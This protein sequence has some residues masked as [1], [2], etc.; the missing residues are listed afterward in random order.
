MSAPIHKAGQAAPFIT[1]VVKVFSDKKTGTFNVEGPYSILDALTDSGLQS[2]L[3]NG[4]VITEKSLQSGDK[5]MGKIVVKTNYYDDPA[6]T[7]PAA[8]IRTTFTIEMEE[9]TYD[10]I[11]HPKFNAY[12][13]NIIRMWL[14]TEESER[15]E[16][17][18][19]TYKGKDGIGRVVMDNTVDLFCAAY[20]AGI[21]T[22]NRY[23]PVIGKNS[24]YSNPP[25]MT[26][27]GGS[28][29]GGSPTFSAGIGT[30]NT[31]PLSLNGY[32]STNWFKSKD[33]WVENANR[34]WTRT[35]QWT[36]TPEGSSGPHAWIY[37]AST[38]GGGGGGG[39]GGNS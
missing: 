17:G 18:I 32:P 8:P 12:Q 4:Y 16:D 22:F 7:E 34:T 37:A 20:M 5:G 27:S 36:Y 2:L 35:E 29:T 13:R 3:P 30:Y 33:S 11:D 10:L 9:V 26:M 6:S 39:E 21:K 1:A 31:P 24:I 38:G 14:A 23:Y 19:Y 25:G 15:M 28:F